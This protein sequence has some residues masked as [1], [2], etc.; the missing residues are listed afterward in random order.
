MVQTSD[1]PHLRIPH[2]IF[3][4]VTMPWGPWDLREDS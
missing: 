2:G 4:T 1:G 3:G